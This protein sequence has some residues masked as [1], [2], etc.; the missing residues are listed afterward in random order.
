MPGSFQVEGKRDRA[1]R[2]EPRSDPPVFR[3][4]QEPRVLHGGEAGHQP[5]RGGDPTCF[6]CL[7]PPHD[8]VPDGVTDRGAARTTAERKVMTFPGRE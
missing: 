1:D 7:G 5:L 4:D 6:R 3:L 2:P 8:P